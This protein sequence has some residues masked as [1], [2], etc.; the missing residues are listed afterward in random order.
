MN[1]L[2]SVEAVTSH[3][4]VM[5]VMPYATVLAAMNAGRMSLVIVFSR[6]GASLPHDESV[7][8]TV[9]IFGVIANLVNNKNDKS[10]SCDSDN[11]NVFLSLTV[12][13]LS[14]GP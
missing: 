14:P 10:N 8:N 12:E 2:S 9:R 7:I 5:P 13:P 3:T 6:R 11:H 1:G 4:T